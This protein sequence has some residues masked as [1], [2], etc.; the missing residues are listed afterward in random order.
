MKWKRCYCVSIKKKINKVKR[1]GVVQ[2]ESSLGSISLGVINCLTLSAYRMSAQGN[3]ING[4]FKASFVDKE[5]RW[6]QV[7]R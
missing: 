4:I 3:Y 6:K 5:L 2:F 7:A 1:L